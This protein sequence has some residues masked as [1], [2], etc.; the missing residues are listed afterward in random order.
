[1]VEYHIP[2]DIR[3]SFQLLSLPSETERA[4][5]RLIAEQN[6]TA[7]PDPRMTQLDALASKARSW[8]IF[9]IPAGGTRHTVWFNS[10]GM[11]HVDEQG[12]PMAW[13]VSPRMRIPP[14]TVLDVVYVQG[15]L[16][17]LDGWSLPSPADLFAYRT[18]PRLL[19]RVELVELLAESCGEDR[20]KVVQPIPLLDWGRNSTIQAAVAK[21][22]DVDPSFDLFFLRDGARPPAL[23]S[24]SWAARDQTSFRQVNELMAYVA[25]KQLPAPASA[26]AAPAASSTS[27]GPPIAVAAAGSR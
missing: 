2:E 4:R 23:P 19:D 22:N 16:Y 18:R 24:Y 17:A 10:Q 12:H 7:P 21:M 3:N 26:A 27:R 6:P 25:S 1:M 8:Y 11:G 5:L 15:I 14:D 13:N 20:L 9:P